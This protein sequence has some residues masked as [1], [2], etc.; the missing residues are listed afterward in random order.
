MQASFD[1]DGKEFKVVFSIFGTEKFYYG[2]QL[3]LSRWSFKLNDRLSFN[4]GN[5]VVEIH[6]MLSRKSWS[7]QA[8]VN[9]ELVVDEL[10]PDIKAKLETPHKGIT[11]RSK[12]GNVVLWFFLAIGFM[13]FFQWL[14]S[15]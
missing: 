6:F 2:D 3:L 9:K 4:L 12:V 5:N 1:V 13:F 10:F 8:F 11:S 14:H 7:T 15:L